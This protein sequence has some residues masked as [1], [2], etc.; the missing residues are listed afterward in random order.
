[1]LIPHKLFLFFFN[2]LYTQGSTRRAHNSREKQSRQRLTTSLSPDFFRDSSKPR[3]CF[4]LHAQNAMGCSKT[5]NEGVDRN[6]VRNITSLAL[7]QI[8]CHTITMW[9]S[10][11]TLK[12]P[13]LKLLL[14]PW[15]IWK[16][17]PAPVAQGCQGRCRASWCSWHGPHPVSTGFIP[18]IGTDAHFD[19]S[20]Y[21]TTF[22][23]ARDVQ[24]YNS[25][26]VSFDLF[27]R[28]V[29][30]TNF[31]T[32]LLFWSVHKSLHRSKRCRL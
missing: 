31:N 25:I 3:S 22:K 6:R 19:F 18:A 12:L 1:M 13:Q 15:T 8:T 26:L 17:T 29:T 27:F 20:A 32:S 28:V 30:I 24:T 5:Q 16:V 2:P 11:I 14:L 7:F 21:S 10:N 4:W 23:H 9:L